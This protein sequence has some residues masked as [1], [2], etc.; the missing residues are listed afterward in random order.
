MLA[1]TE[2]YIYT[3]IYVISLFITFQTFK[4]ISSSPLRLSHHLQVACLSKISIPPT[5]PCC[6]AR[7]F[8]PTVPKSC[9]ELNGQHQKKKKGGVLFT[10][11]S[12]CL[13]IKYQSQ[14]KQTRQIYEY[15]NPHVPSQLL[16]SKLSHTVSKKVPQVNWQS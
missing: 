14:L 6:N 8:H 5:R 1:C 13:S 4:S 15:V 16:K 11:L 2:T 10:R 9:R 7:A 3:Y 12:L